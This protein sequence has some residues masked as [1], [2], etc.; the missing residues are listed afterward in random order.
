MEVH[1]WFRRKKE[2]LQD[3]V[4][5]EVNAED[6]ARVAADPRLLLP[7]AHLTRQQIHLFWF[8]I[9]ASFHDYHAYN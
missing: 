1:A 6:S 3:R 2:S 9:R 8:L 4:V 5:G 7:L